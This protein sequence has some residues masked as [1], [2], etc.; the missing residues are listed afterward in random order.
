VPGPFLWLI[1]AH[2]IR[3]FAHRLPYPEAQPV[4]AHW[5]SLGYITITIAI[6]KGAQP[7]GFDD[8]VRQWAS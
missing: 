7:Q 4:E 2:A 8:A 6:D 3:F 1:E 5:L